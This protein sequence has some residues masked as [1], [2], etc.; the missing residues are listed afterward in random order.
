MPTI[1]V[2][3]NNSASSGTNG[4]SGVLNFRSLTSPPCFMYD[5]LANKLDRAIDA[6]TSIAPNPAIESSHK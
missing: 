1:T 3:F 6:Q 5:L 4:Y 2:T